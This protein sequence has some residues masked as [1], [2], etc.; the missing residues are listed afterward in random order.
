MASVRNAP[1]H[2]RGNTSGLPSIRDER[3]DAKQ[4]NRRELRAIRAL[5]LTA[6]MLGL[7]ALVLLGFKLFEGQAAANNANTLLEAYKAK[8]TVLPTLSP[9]A[10]A[11]ETLSPTDEP[12]GTPEPTDT[13]YEQTSAD[14][15]ANAAVDANQHV[16]DD[17]SVNSSSESGEYVQP[18]APE[19]ISDLDKTIQK[20]VNATGDDGMIGILEI[21]EINQELP[22]IGKW[23][24]KLLKISVCR[25]KGPD[26]NEKGNLVIIGH[27]YKSG[28]HF[29]D[30]SE[31]SVGSEVFLTNAKTGQRVRYVVYQ[32]KS[33]APDAFSALNSYHGTAGLT[34]M[35]CR[36][37]GTNRLL[38]RCEQKE[39][40]PT[41][42]PTITPFKTP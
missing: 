5:G 40:D 37:N 26:P 22:I 13:N 42:T 21:P 41:P 8:A 20:I 35:T 19:E 23:S 36:N 2:K 34:L 24:Y 10:E 38:V 31:L 25:Y 29:G 14:A 9:S 28:A 18:D 1:S 7:V 30:L 3:H 12:V 32:I 16:A 4:K 39:A 33:I 27:N 17:G 11:T 6:I 15:D